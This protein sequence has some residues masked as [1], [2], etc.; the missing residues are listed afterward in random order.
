MDLTPLHRIRRAL[1]DYRRTTI[2]LAEYEPAAVLM[3][4][5]ECDAG[6]CA[7]FTVRTDDVEHHK[8]E[9]SFPGGRVEAEDPD[10]RSAALRETWEEVGI[11]PEH[12]E[13]L[14]TLDDCVSISGYRVTPFV[15][16]LSHVPYPL[17]AQ[18]SEVSEILCIPLD[19]L[20]A[21]ENQRVERFGTQPIHHFHWKHHVV[22]GLTGNILHHFLDLVWPQHETRG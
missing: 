11:R 5:H 22:W 13:I 7:L 1:G 21:P 12:L 8:G 2:P 17:R 16:M 20:R 18:P 10:E 3:V 19:H 4:L 15:A 6:L 9:I 14:G